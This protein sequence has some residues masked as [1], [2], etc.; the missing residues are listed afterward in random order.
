M[1]FLWRKFYR[2]SPTSIH[3]R[4]LGDL[5]HDPIRKTNNKNLY[6]SLHKGMKSN[7]NY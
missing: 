4:D 5:H 2:I 1:I 7:S 3:H 6:K